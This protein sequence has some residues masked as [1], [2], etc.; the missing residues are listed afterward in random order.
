MRPLDVDAPASFIRTAQGQ[1]RTAAAA[2][3]TRP[4]WIAFYAQRGTACDPV[5][6][7]GVIPAYSVIQS[8]VNDGYLHYNALDVNLHHTF[9]HKFEALASYTWSHTQDNVDPDATGQNPNDPLQTGRA[10][11]GNALYDQRNRV[12]LSGFWIAPLAIHVGGIASLASGLPYNLT[13]GATNSG[14]TGA[15]TDRPVINGVVVGR[16]TGRGT[17][18][19]A[20]RSLPQPRLPPLPRARQARPPCRSLQRPQP[21]QLRLLRRHLRQHQ[22]RRSRHPGHPQ[23]RRHRPTP[24]PLPPVRRQGLLLMLCSNYVTIRVPHLRRGL[25]RRR[26]DVQTVG[27]H[28][29]AN[30]KECNP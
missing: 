5:K 15:T 8:D 13:T 18:I 25:M 11:Y 21:R 26:W 29:L 6:N 12:V 7:A 22:H 14:D 28:G 20:V 27:Q 23:L 17:P 4:L 10:E 24:R 16:N 9:S 19:Y 30:E 2:N 3:C 1:T